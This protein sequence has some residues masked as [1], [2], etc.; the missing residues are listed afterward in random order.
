MT[1]N[2]T[3]D[4]KGEPLSVNNVLLDVCAPQSA[5][6]KMFTCPAGTSELSG[7]GF[8]DHAA[9]SWLS[10][11]TALKGGETITVDFGV[12][13]AGDG[14]YNSSVLVDNLRWTATQ[15]ILIKP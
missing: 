12:M 14:V 11:T 1:N 2:I 8:E 5:G 7:T 13:D 4:S 6:G 15:G 10:T 9:T 3:F